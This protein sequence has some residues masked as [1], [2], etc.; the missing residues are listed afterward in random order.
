M[1][2]VR[3]INTKLAPGASLGS[4]T[5]QSSETDCM[6]FPSHGGFGF[7]GA[8]YMFPEDEII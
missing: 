5:V 8:C 2:N 3:Q 1:V 4:A 6:P 7:I